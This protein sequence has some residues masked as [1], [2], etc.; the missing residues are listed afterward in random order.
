MKARCKRMT[1]EGVEVEDAPSLRHVVAA[2]LVAAD[3]VAAL[4]VP[5]L[6]FPG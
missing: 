5:V 4:R 6:L 3:G 1:G 2:G